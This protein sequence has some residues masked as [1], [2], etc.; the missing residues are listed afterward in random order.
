[1]V[2]VLLLSLLLLLLQGRYQ[3]LRKNGEGSYCFVN[4]DVFEGEFRDD[5]MAGTGVYSFSPEGR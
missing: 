4:G 5:R 1:M 2:L 3:G